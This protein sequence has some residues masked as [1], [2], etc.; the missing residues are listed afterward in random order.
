MTKRKF[1]EELLQALVP[2]IYAP[3]AEA[4][5]KRRMK[6]VKKEEKIEKKEEDELGD[7][8]GDE[9]ELLHASAPR[10]RVNWK[11]R[12]VRR[13]LRPGTVVSFTPGERSAWRGHKRSYDEV[14]GDEDILEQALDRSG[15]FAYGKR[16]RGEKDV[17][18]ALD[19]S[20][21]TPS[22]K[23]V[24]EQKVMPVS[25]PGRRAPKREAGDMQ[26][27]MQLLVPKRQKLEDV[28]DFLKME[29]DVQPDVKIR[30][31][32]EVAPGL[33]VQTIDIQI[34]VSSASGA[35]EVM[36]TEALNSAV[37]APRVS[38]GTSADIVMASAPVDS[39]VQTDPWS[40]APVQS[41]RG[42]RRYGPASGVMPNYLLHPSIIPTPGYRGVP[43][44]RRR[45]ATATRRQR[46][47][48]RT[49]RVA[50]VRV[51]R[52]TTRRGR[53]LTLPDV[54]YHPSIVV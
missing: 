50:P 24:T 3:V 43:Y 2:E 47:R 54:R 26:P 40:Q 17:A 23:A 5:P 46:R 29:P 1:K 35:L 14:Y 8:L 34:P 28:L 32:K 51:R 6:R 10:R 53:R 52:V 22:L 12:K 39:G 42:R 13:V 20:N 31:I 49:T 33:G 4:K 7:V 48:R 45:G 27:T 18:L 30:P 41:S 16:S 9:V 11:G 36:E 38:T 19:T 21:P 44:S 25:L 15:E 37:P